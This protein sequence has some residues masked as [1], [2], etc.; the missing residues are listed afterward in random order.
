RPRRAWPAGCG[1]R[2]G[3]SAELP[4]CARADG[5]LSR[6]PQALGRAGP[7][8]AR[9]VERARLLAVAARDLDGPDHP[10]VVPDAFG[11][12][13]TTGLL[14]VGEP[15]G[16]QR[17]GARRPPPESAA[18]RGRGVVCFSFPRA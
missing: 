12:A 16:R 11:R 17:L 8:A 4:A 18:R 6:L 3:L 7:A 9:A 13:R 10:D 2:R 14:P 5:R 15:A 1:T